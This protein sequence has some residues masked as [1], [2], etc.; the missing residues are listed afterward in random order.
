[1]VSN[2]PEKLNNQSLTNLNYRSSAEVWIFLGCAAAAMIIL[3]CF[4]FLLCYFLK[5]HGKQ[6][7][8]LLSYAGK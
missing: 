1:M 8:H 2:F 6:V 3:M 5:N 4:C 7:N